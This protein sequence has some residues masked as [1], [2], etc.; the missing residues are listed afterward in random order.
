[1]TKIGLIC[2]SG[3]ILDNYI[4]NTDDILCWDE[5]SDEMDNDFNGEKT[6]EES[7]K[8]KNSGNEKNWYYSLFLDQIISDMN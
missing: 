5:T 2:K 6:K 8:E 3:W 4:P 7:I 1:M